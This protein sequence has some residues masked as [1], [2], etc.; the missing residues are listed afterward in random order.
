M[1]SRRG[2]R[3]GGARAGGGGG[4]GRETLIVTPHARRGVWSH[5]VTRRS[6]TPDRHRR[7]LVVSGSLFA[8]SGLLLAVSGSLLVLSRL[9]TIAPG[10][11]VFCPFPGRH[12]QFCNRPV[13]RSRLLRS[14][15]YALSCFVW[16]ANA[17]EQLRSLVTRLRMFS[18]SPGSPFSCYHAQSAMQ[19]LLEVD[20]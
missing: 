16:R 11:L 13:V 6:F 8:L 4:G 12:L 3:R 17:F 5:S 18:F 14:R 2:E 7:L 1:S 9:R 10:A 19:P 15:T 20:V